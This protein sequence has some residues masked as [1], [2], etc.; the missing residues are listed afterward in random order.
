MSKKVAMEGPVTSH[1]NC[2][3]GENLF[4]L[5]NS[6]VTDVSCEELSARL[7]NLVNFFEQK[8][9]KRPLK[10]IKMPG[11]VNLIG[12]H[13]DYCGFPVCPMALDKDILLAVAIANTSEYFLQ[14]HNVE[15]EKY[16]YS[17]VKEFTPKLNISFESVGWISYIL[18]G[19]Q[20]VIDKNAEVNV[21][22]EP[23][24][25]EIAVSG[26]I[27]ASAGLSS[28]SALVCAAF[29]ATALVN[30]MIMSKTEMATI[31]GE[32]EH[33]IGTAGG[34]MDQAIAFNGKKGCSLMIKFNPLRFKD[35]LLPDGAVV[36]IANSLVEKNKAASNDFN[37]RVVECRIA[38]QIMAKAAKVENWKTL[39][40]LSDVKLAL[41]LSL[42]ETLAYVEKI[43]DD[44]PYTK[45]K[46]CEILEVT[47]EELNE[48]SLTPNTYNVREFKLKH[49]AKHV[50]SEA[51]RVYTWRNWCVGGQSLKDLGRILQKSHF[52][53][54]YLYEC[55]HPD[56][57]KLVSVFT[58][59]GAYGARVTGAGWGGCVV[60]L[61]TYANI[62]NIKLHLKTMYYD[63]IVKDVDV[64]KAVFVVY[65][66]DGAELFY[67]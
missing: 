65:P 66:S 31:C 50:F 13:I 19:I 61:T 49:R 36:M 43:F 2:F 30:N 23:H 39:H 60:A 56:V 6:F 35:V 18:C 29:L 57:D 28:S 67:L 1:D 59:S 44:D 46:I 52:S 37:T 25:M 11:R 38:G 22:Y 27:P 10:I 42:T 16:P 26:N 24:F 41:D 7:K 34:G 53:L 32:A 9:G 20:G 48:I 12:E 21:F 17:F 40:K 5:R 62:A 63:Q 15:E 64:D 14:C 8:Y 3:S 58:L 4:G 47:E 55:S 54:Q 51:E 45:E 33:Y